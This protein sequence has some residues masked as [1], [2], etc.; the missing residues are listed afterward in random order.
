MKPNYYEI[1]GIERTASEA[2]IRQRFRELAREFHPDR[3]KSDKAQAEKRFQSLTEAVNVLTNSAKRKQHDAETQSLVGKSAGESSQVSK[4]YMIKGVKAYNEGSYTVAR[5]HFDMA[6]KHDP[7]D[8][9]GFYYLALASAR[10]P[11][12]MRQAV[13]AIESAVQLESFNPLYLKTAG[14]LC[15]R[16]GLVAK[17][18]RLLEL[19][20]QWD[21]ENPEIREALEQLRRTRSESKEGGKG[22]LD[23]LFKKG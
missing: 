11:A 18:E 6:V 16:A 15:M 3:H 4:A 5:D 14:L 8:A 10:N 23:S 17:A 7:A 9:K 20:L 21:Q 19:A 22:L 12:T 2:Q 1:L 13:Q